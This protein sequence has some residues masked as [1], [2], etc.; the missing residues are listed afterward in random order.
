MLFYKCYILRIIQ[1]GKDLRRPVVQVPTEN[2]A[3]V[4]I[5]EGLPSP[6]GSWKQRTEISLFG[7][8]VPL[9]NLSHRK[10]NLLI[11]NCSFFPIPSPCS[12]LCRSWKIAFW[13]VPPP[14]WT[15][16]SSTTSAGRLNTPPTDHSGCLLPS[17]FQF[18]DISS[19]IRWPQIGCCI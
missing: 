17:L 10:K 12:S 16:I 8:T 15:S 5:Q 4:W 18:L 2:R 7:H 1:A 14:M 3:C 6:V 13:S 9:L 11:Y 19:C